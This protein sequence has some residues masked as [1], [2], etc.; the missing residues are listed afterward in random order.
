MK[1]FSLSTK[2]AAL[3]VIVG[4][5]WIIISDVLLNYILHLGLVAGVPQTLKGIVFIAVTGAL[6]FLII[7]QMDASRSRVEQEAEMLASAAK[8]SLDII[9]LHDH[10]GKILFITPSVANTLGYEPSDFINKHPSIL[11]HPDDIERTR[12]AIRGVK[13]GNEQQFTY[14]AKHKNRFR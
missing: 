5:L 11:H 1:S 3:Y 13:E 10:D 14:R 6:L 4:S 8:G 9:A 12:T 2:V 7:R